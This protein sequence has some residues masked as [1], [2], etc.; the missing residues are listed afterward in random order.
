[1]PGSLLI[2]ITYLAGTAW[3]P[4]ASITSLPSSLECARTRVLVAA[5]IQKVASSNSTTSVEFVAVGDD[6][7]VLVGAIGREVARLSCVSS[8]GG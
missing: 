4:N 3:G 5:S 7:V 1:M 2:V 6:L 8:G